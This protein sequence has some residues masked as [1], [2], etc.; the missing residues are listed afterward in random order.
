MAGSARNRSPRRRRFRRRSHLP[1]RARYVRVGRRGIK[2]PEE[3]REPP[4]KMPLF[5]RN[6]PVAM[7]EAAV[8]RS[9]FSRNR[10]TGWTSIPSEP[11][12]PTV[13]PRL[14]CNR[15]GLGTIRCDAERH[16]CIL[17]LRGSQRGMDHL[18][19]AVRVR[20]MMIRREHGDGCIRVIT[21][22]EETRG[23]EDETPGGGAP[24]G[25]RM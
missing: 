22:R 4:E 6:R 21:G 8:S 19:E 7:Y 20:D 25:S 18:T 24:S 9:G 3:Y 1:C 5:Q 11:G 17:A 12:I 16:E 15:N 23:G 13:S 2:F 14:R 10:E